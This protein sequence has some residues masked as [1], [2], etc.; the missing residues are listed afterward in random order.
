VRISV[1]TKAASV[2]AL[3]LA[4][5]TGWLWY[6]FFGHRHVTAQARRADFR[7]AADAL[8]STNAPLILATADHFYWLNNGPAAGPLYARAEKLFSETGDKRNELHAH[9]GNLR[10]EAETMSFVDL[11][12][13]LDQQLQTSLLRNDKDLRLWCLIAKGYTDIEIDYRATKRD[14]LEARALAKTLGQDQWVTRANGELG[15]VAFLEGNPGHAARLMGGALLSTMASGDIGGQI[16]FLELLGRGFEEVNRHAEAMRFFDRAI[17]LADGEKDSGMPFMAYEGK[18]QALVALGKPNDAKAVI[19]GA[20]EKA[21]A[22][23]KRGHEAQLLILLGTVAESTGDKTQAI[24]Y[25]EQAAQFAA[26]VQFYRMEADATFELAKLYRDSGDL[27]KAD[28]RATEGLAASQRVGD[29]YYVPRN[30]TIL[31]DL[32]ARRGRV[33]EANALYEQAE[34]VIEGML[35]SVDEPYWNSSVAASMS[36]TYLQHFELAAKMGDIPNAF[37][38]LERV[39]GRT[40]EWALKDKKAFP[41]A[42][43]DQTTALDT[44]IA[45][46]QGQL[47]QASDRSKR[48]QLLDQLVEYERRLGLAWTRDEAANQRL[49]VQPASLSSIQDE[50]KTDEVLLEYVLDDP[51]SFCLSITRSGTHLH[52]LPAGRKQIEKLAHSFIDQ[53]RA[54]QSGDDVSRQLYRSLLQP[55]TAAQNAA[56]LMIVPDGILNLLPFEAL[57]DAKD[58]YLLRSTTPSYVPSATI[59]A[60]LRR[61]NEAPAGRPLLAVGDVPYEGQ[62]GAGQRIPKPASFRGRVERGIADLSGM[63]L[64]DL[65]ETREEVEQ[66]GKLAGP[67]SILLIGKDATETVFK[68]EPLDQFRV[69]HLAVHG[70]ADTQFP[71]RSALVLGADPKTG[72]DGL[73]Q[74]REI[75]RL[76]LKAELTTLSA[77]D[78]GV[79]KLQGQEGISNL[80][81]AFLVA[82]SKS[83]VASLWSAEDTSASAVM[84]HFYDHLAHGEDTSS[85][86][87]SAKLDLLTK[88]GDQLSPYYWAEFVSVG[89][90]STPVGITK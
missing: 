64:S 32:K 81:E 16:R 14:W 11:S 13:Y 59:L 41:T 51:T 45:N 27:A 34:D 76:H 21:R 30:L 85:A 71:E 67:T 25:L 7:S 10:S 44:E 72:D 6:A 3:I 69:L 66:I 73:L 88:F 36:Q 86:L 29:R 79:G 17:K 33:D 40:L 24:Q 80:V 90:T 43:S 77:C 62:G 9:I 82:G 18:A 84:E 20:L 70:F 65:P 74:V 87:R 42:E 26:S 54:K 12:R 68:K 60:T 56:R 55:I 15:L 39:R 2:V 83:V 46:V 35:I 38:I 89:E 47:M 61:G 5:V 58:Q 37:R 78:T 28:A 52:Q 75:I 53:I 49:P 31:A 63:A 48:E 19:E 4:V 23:Q 50:L 8:Q 22:Q 1:L 57:R